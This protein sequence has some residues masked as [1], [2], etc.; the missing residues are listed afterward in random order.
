MKKLAEVWQFSVDDEGRSVIR[1]WSGRCG[2][3]FRVEVVYGRRS[4][5]HAKREI[6]AEFGTRK[7]AK[8]L[9]RWFGRH[10]RLRAEVTRIGGK[11][12]R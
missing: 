4:K 9:V 6:V 5:G 8:K 12:R 2:P 10:G 11:V 3:R 7:E 1:T